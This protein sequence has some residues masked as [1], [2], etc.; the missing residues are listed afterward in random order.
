MKQ[1]K[2]NNSDFLYSTMIQSIKISAD[3]SRKE[4]YELGRKGPYCRYV[5]FPINTTAFD[6]PYFYGLKIIRGL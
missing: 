1:E 3:L 6:H 2:N 5:K 4:I